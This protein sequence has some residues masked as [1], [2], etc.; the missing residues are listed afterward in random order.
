MAA[1]KKTERKLPTADEVVQGYRP[2]PAAHVIDDTPPLSEVLA[3]SLAAHTDD[4]T[5]PTS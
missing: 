5:P 3:E 1:A 4:T 2:P